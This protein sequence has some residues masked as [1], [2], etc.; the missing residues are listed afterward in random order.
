M[1][2]PVWVRERRKNTRM[3]ARLV[4]LGL[5]AK[6]AGAGTNGPLKSGPILAGTWFPFA[7][8]FC[9]FESVTG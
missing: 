4:G 9:H 5:R 1:L 7:D 6:G 2:L 8:L 3:L